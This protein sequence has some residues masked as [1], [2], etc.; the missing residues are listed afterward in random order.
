MSWWEYVE[1][2]ANTSRQRDISDRTGIDATNV[3]RWKSGQVPKADLVAQFARGYGRPVLEAFVAAGFLTPE[4]AKVRPAPAPDF[5]QLSNDELLELV[6]QRM[7]ETDGTATK[8]AGDAPANPPPPPRHL[9]AART[10]KSPRR[11]QAR[12][13]QQ[14]GDAEGPQSP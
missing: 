9:A 4:E 6:R 3:T 8:D 10:T 5:S 1:R 14:D 7:G 2:I 11:S 13:L 12:R